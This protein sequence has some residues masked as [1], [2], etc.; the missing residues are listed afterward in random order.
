[1]PDKTVFHISAI[2]CPDRQ[3]VSNQ[4]LP[5]AELWLKFLFLFPLPFFILFR[6]WH[7]PAR[8][9][10]KLPGLICGKISKKRQKFAE[11][12]ASFVFHSRD[13]PEF[14]MKSAD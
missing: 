5:R 10:R 8:P 13:L 14:G 3:S 4:S 12:A 1:M 9:H 2:A 6:N 7:I 11:T